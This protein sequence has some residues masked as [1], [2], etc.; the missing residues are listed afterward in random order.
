MD[1]CCEYDEHSYISYQELTSIFANYM[2]E[3]SD[4]VQRDHV[5]DLAFDTLGPLIKTFEVGRLQFSPG[6]S[7]LSAFIDN[8]LILGLKVVRFR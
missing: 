1:S 2:N 5:I 4:G 8:T 6:R 3:H 7:Q